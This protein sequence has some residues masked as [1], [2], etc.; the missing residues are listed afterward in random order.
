[1]AEISSQI[2]AADK[3]LCLSKASLSRLTAL[4]PL[5]YDSIELLSGF[6]GRNDR[7][8]VSP[9]SDLDD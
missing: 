4:S 2:A 6:R 9:T 5:K 8:K 3:Y 1:M 7:F